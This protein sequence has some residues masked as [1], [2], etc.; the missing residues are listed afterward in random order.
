MNVLKASVSIVLVLVLGALF[1]GCVSTHP[2]GGS[3]IPWSN[4]ASWENQVP[5]MGGASPG[6]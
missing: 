6:R 4:P 1:T 3:T 5:G 2:A